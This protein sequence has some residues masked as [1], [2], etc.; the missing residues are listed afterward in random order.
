MGRPPN[1]EARDTREAILDAALDVFAEKGFHGASMKEIAAVVG[2][3]NSA[4]YHYFESKEVLVDAI[5]A[6]RS[7]P[8]ILD[9]V[10][11]DP[12]TDARV[13]LERI[14]DAIVER[15]ES[16]RTQKLFRVLMADGLR[17]HA[18]KRVN[19]LRYFDG[20]QFTKLMERMIKEKMLRPG[21]P[22]L[23]AMEFVAP[24]H[25]LMMLRTLQPNH[26]LGT[27]PDAFV[28]AHVEQFLRGASTD[29]G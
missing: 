1:A 8:S 21:Q 23:L 13:V 15:M 22:E 14:A 28:R 24:F 26:P 10:L 16:P 2:V 9:W 18:E 20:R 27:Y 4:I 17:L 11:E 29:H 5:L 3:R 6:E 19:L 25:I 12:I 7:N